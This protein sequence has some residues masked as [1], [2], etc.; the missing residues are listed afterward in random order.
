[1]Y[2][3]NLSK[4]WLIKNIINWL[5]IIKHHRTFEF[6]IDHTRF[7]FHFRSIRLIKSPRSAEFTEMRWVGG[8]I[9]GRNL[10]WKV[11]LIFKE[12]VDRRFWRLKN[13]PKRWRS[14]CGIRAFPHRQLSEIKREIGKEVSKFTLKNL[15]KK[16]LSMEANQVGIVE[17]NQWRWEGICPARPRAVDEKSRSGVT[18]FSLFWWGGF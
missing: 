9:G 2:R 15:I 7:Y 18:R 12:K 16:R 3:I 13:K 5:G 6:A 11:W 1:M 8:S 10:V 17:T 14:P 4:L